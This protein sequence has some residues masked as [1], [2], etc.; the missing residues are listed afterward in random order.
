MSF[1]RVVARAYSDD[2]RRKLLEAH[3][4]GEGTLRGLSD[5]FS[6]S[7]QWAYKIS[8]ERRRTGSMDRRPQLRRGRESRV[9]TMQIERLL[10]S[11][12]DMTLPEL[13]AELIAATGLR[14]SVP[15]LWR[16]VRKMGSRRKK[17]RSTPSSVTPKSIAAAAK[18]S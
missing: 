18:R 1:S 5:R 7:L 9:N 2:L 12:S 11:R 13:Q 3:D 14:T 15:H 8:A 17:N 4:R 10:E 16:V 6:V